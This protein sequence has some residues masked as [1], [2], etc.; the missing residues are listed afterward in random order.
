MAADASDR[1]PT[2]PKRVKAFA[3]F[4][5][6]YMSISSLVVASLPI[7]VTSFGLIP[8]F[9]AQTKL[10]SVYTSLFCFLAL[11]F[12]FYSRH[13]LARLMFPEFFDREGTSDY[14]SSELSES[15]QKELERR[16]RKRNYKKMWRTFVVFLPLVFIAASL[17]AVFQYNDVLQLNVQ[18]IAYRH[19]LVEYNVDG[20][21]VPLKDAFKMILENTDLNDIKYSSRLMILYIAI[22]LMAEA[23][24]IM[25]AIKEYLQDLVGLT[26]MSLIL[27]YDVTSELTTPKDG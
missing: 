11:G 16:A 5:K 22:F 23:A 25:M 27:G 10:L 17:V 14:A 18:E 8:T 4:F 15:E 24:F 1:T 2:D 12:I 26:E 3:N 6:R 9:A 7:P 19:K 13:Q 20:S 21:V